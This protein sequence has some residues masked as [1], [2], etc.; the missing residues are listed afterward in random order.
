MKTWWCQV[1]RSSVDALGYGERINTESGCKAVKMTPWV[2]AMV[3][4]REKLSFWPLVSL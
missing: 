2:G 3:R 1:S 4:R